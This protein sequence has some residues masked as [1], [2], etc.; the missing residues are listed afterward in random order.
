MGTHFST[1][2]VGLVD[3]LARSLDAGL[4]CLGLIWIY[5]ARSQ[6]LT[7]IIEHL[8]RLKLA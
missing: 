3:D 6:G 4:K 7:E 1:T 5:A 2:G 8:L